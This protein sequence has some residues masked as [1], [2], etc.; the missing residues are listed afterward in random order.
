[1]SA[2]TFGAATLATQA[3]TATLVRKEKMF[4]LFIIYIAIPFYTVVGV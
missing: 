1:M 4:C 2:S 3:T